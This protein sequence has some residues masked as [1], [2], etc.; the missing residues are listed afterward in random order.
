MAR[1]NGVTG[2]RRLQSGTDDARGCGGAVASFVCVGIAIGLLGCREAEREVGP[3]LLFIVVDTLRVDHVGSY[4]YG[5]DTTPVLDGLAAEGLRFEYAY[6][7][8]SWTKP[9]VASM[10]TGQ[11]PSRHRVQKLEHRLPDES[12]TLAEI[13]ARN[14]YATAGV[15][16]H[17]LLSSQYGFDQGFEHWVEDDARGHTHVSSDGVSDSAIELLGR[18]GDDERPFFLFVH[19]FDPHFDYRPH[20]GI[21][22]AGDAAGRVRG[23]QPIAELLALDPPPNEDEVR[24]LLGLY[25][26][27]IRFTDA[28]IGRLLDALRESG[29]G[30]DTLIV[31]T[32]DHGEEFFE[33][34]WLGHARTLYEEQIRVP[35]ILRMPAGRRETGVVREPVSLVG[36]TPSILHVLG[37]E[38]PGLDFQFQSE[39]FL[40]PPAPAA[41]AT[42]R[43][44]FSEIDFGRR[45]KRDELPRRRSGHMRSLVRGRHKLI[46]DRHTDRFELYPS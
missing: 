40:R 25:D 31:F 38:R 13:L 36:L 29:R 7:S 10:L 22:F 15:V 28:A 8:A 30:G 46:H 16:S 43:G 4:G 32:A 17:K 19:Y 35:L 1:V 18:L 27:E 23:G 24:F 20:A 42:P 26:E 41:G 3:N 9:S 14:G 39:S 33:R 6:A 44:L 12:D 45:A 2:K 11:F 34:G 5:R 21:D 37:F